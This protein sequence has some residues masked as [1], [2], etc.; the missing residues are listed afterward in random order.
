MSGQVAKLQVHCWGKTQTNRALWL[1]WLSVVSLWL[2]PI[3]PLLSANSRWAAGRTWHCWP[4]SRSPLVP[5]VPMA[6][7]ALTWPGHVV[8]HSSCSFHWRQ[9]GV[10]GDPVACFCRVL[11]CPMVPEGLWILSYKCGLK[12]FTSNTR[13]E[14]GIAGLC[15]WE[16][17]VVPL[18]YFVYVLIVHFSLN[19]S[20]TLTLLALVSFS[21]NL[22]FY[23]DK[24]QFHCMVFNW[25]HFFTVV[26]RIEVNHQPVVF[27]GHCH[28]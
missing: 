25:L 26:I 15:V 1:G 14:Q 10:M 22:H 20:G 21:T 13:N 2:K 11:G 16:V 28:W 27:S 5:Y 6:S 24:H 7:V 19:L 9:C 23:L 4:C 12:V 17:P 3:P 8:L 18:L